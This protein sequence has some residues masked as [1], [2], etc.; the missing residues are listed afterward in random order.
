MIHKQ[1]LEN[2]SSIRGMEN[3]QEGDPKR[4]GG[5]YKNARDLESHLRPI[6]LF[7]KSGKVIAWSLL[8]GKVYNINSREESF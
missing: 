3:S 6:F 7:A 4:G 5:Y 8:T 2:R 1:A